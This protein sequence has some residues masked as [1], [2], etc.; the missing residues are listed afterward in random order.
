MN[1]Q[2][3]NRTEDAECEPVSPSSPRAFCLSAGTWFCF[4]GA[5]LFV[6]GACGAAWQVF[7]SE[8]L[9]RAP[10]RWVDL[11]THEFQYAGLTA[12]VHVLGFVGGMMLLA[13]GLGLRA[14][15]PASATLAL[16]ATSLLVVFYVASVVVWLLMG[17]YVVAF[18]AF[19]AAGLQFFLF[20][21]A[22]GCRATF[23]AH[24]PPP[25]QNTVTEAQLEEMR[26]RRRSRYD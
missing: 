12:L 17:R 1:E 19:L 5:L 23:R 2:E 25:D 3:A 20:L 16:G 4:L 14:E 8:P 10:N 18:L 26:N 13:A 9:P 15:R 11:L 7:L 6:S 22:A 21:A 24:P